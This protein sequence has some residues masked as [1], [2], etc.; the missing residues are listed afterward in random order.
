MRWP[1]QLLARS[2]DAHRS[3]DAFAATAQDPFDAR[4][5]FTVD[6]ADWQANSMPRG[7]VYTCRTCDAQVQIQIT[8]GPEIPADKRKSNEQFISDIGGDDVARKRFADSMMRSMV[9][10]VPNVSIEV[11]R[12]G[13]SKLGGLKVFQMQSRVEMGAQRSH[14]TSMLAIHRNRI[15]K[16]TLNYFDGA[17]D[18]ETELSNKV[19]SFYRSFEFK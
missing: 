4:E 10:A 15:V 18:A 16:V 9:P 8:F 14:D 12:T 17:M 11:T 3:S 6:A 1:T 19:A 5:A 7:M 13:I 2:N